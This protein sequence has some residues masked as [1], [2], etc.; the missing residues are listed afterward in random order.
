MGY[1]STGG[2]MLEAVK[3]GSE[4]GVAVSRAMQAREE[5]EYGDTI[6]L[7]ED[8]VTKC[9]A[10]ALG[11]S[12]PCAAPL[13]QEGKLLPEEVVTTCFDESF[14]SHPSKLFVINSYPACL[15]EVTWCVP[16]SPGDCGVPSY[17]SGHRPRCPPRGVRTRRTT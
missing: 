12:Q 6:L 8:T 11:L 4:V 2:V 10:L 9:L 16:L 1:F 15:T 3:A 14:T 17:A 13:P 5:E 7:I